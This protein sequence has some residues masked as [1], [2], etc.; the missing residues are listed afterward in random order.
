[1]DHH[2]QV[3]LVTGANSGIGKQIATNLARKGFRVVM[4]CR[5]MERGC[6]ALEDILGTVSG[7]S[8]DLMQ[9]DQSSQASIRS[10]ALDYAERYERLDVLMNNAGIY[11]PAREL[12]VDGIESCWATNVMGYFLLTRALQ[13]RLVETPGARLLFVASTKAGGLDLS[14]I[15][16]ARRKYNG[17]RAYEHSKQANRM[18]AWVFDEKLRDQG[19][20]VNV[21]HP[22]GVSTGIGRNQKGLWGLLVR[23]A[24]LTQKSVKDGADTA[25][26]LASASELDGVSGKFWADRKER[27][28]E[29]R[30]MASCH[31][32]WAL[33]ASLEAETDTELS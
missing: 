6:S 26:W 11:P 32:L 15:Q 30:D 17:I 23:L 20:T 5:S 24:F 7:A 31:K 21:I 25:T 10:F 28:C 12:S 4:A 13:H 22:G 9:L 14:D 33:C 8:V 27:V 1:M 16:I 19:V 18:L 29:F 3:A 2:K